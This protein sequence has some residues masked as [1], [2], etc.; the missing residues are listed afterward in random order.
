MICMTF[1]AFI[2]DSCLYV[3]RQS[4]GDVAYIE[5][6]IGYFVDAAFKERNYTIELVKMFA[7]T[8]IGAVP[9]MFGAFRDEKMS[10]TAYKLKD[11]SKDDEYGF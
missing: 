10:V 5:E 3:I 1:A 2:L 6:M 9:A 4:P 8:L 7:F 11:V